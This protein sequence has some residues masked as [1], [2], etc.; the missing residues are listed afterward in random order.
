MQTANPPPWKGANYFF[1]STNPV[2]TLEQSIDLIAAGFTPT[3]I[4]TQKPQPGVR[5]PAAIRIRSDRRPRCADPDLPRRKRRLPADAR[6]R[7]ANVSDRWELIGRRT[8]RSHRRS[9]GAVSSDRRP[10]DRHDERRLS[11]M[12]RSSMSSPTRSAPTSARTATRL[13]KALRTVDQHLVLRTPD[14]YNDWLPQ[15]AAQ[16]PLGLVRQYRPPPR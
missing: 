9:H 7:A 15:H 11:R 10:P 14:L 4:D 16:N 8:F 5:R 3:A 2:T 13:A 12:V 1:A 6:G